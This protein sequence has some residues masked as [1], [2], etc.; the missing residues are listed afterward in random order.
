MCCR[1]YTLELG[2]YTTG[3]G[4]ERLVRSRQSLTEWH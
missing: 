1:N 3:L 2:G 4:V